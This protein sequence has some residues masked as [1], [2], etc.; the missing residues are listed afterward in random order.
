MLELQAHYGLEY[1]RQLQERA[2]R[3]DEEAKAKLWELW[4][5]RRQRRQVAYG[6]PPPQLGAG[7]EDQG[8]NDDALLAA[9][10]WG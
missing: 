10:G 6:K 9:R 2:D 5:K 4:E 7:T 8:S 3:N 1:E